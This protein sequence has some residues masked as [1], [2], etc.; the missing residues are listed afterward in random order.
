MT[1]SFWSGE[2]VFYF[3]PIF[4]IGLKKKRTVIS[5]LKSICM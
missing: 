4:I 5:K 3:K 1:V 2:N